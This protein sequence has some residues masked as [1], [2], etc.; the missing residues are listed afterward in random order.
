MMLVE[1]HH[2][3]VSSTYLLFQS[4]TVFY[5]LLNHHREERANNDQNC[6]HLFDSEKLE[7]TSYP[8]VALKAHSFLN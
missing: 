2:L 7:D 4:S 5:Y 8:Q 1:C 6:S 3:S